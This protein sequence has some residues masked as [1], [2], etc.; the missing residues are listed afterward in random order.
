MSNMPAT[1]LEELSRHIADKSYEAAMPTSLANPILH[2]IGRDLRVI[3]LFQS[4]EDTKK[5]HLSSPMY[6]ILHLVRGRMESNG[7]AT[8]T[9]KLN[10]ASLHRLVE[11][12]QYFIERELVARM[13]G[14]RCE[15][16][17]EELLEAI[18]MHVSAP[19]DSKG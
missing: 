15:K 5:V 12:Y 10:N 11:L 14:V 13:V 17:S 2:Q 7:I 6:L 18:D 9:L 4:S 3:E 19:P 8:D 1:N 16:D